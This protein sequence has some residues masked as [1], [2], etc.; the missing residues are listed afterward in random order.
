MSVP[1]FI[2]PKTK[3]EQ[4]FSDLDERPE[5]SLA[6]QIM[7]LKEEKDSHEG[8]VKEINKELD[9]WDDKETGEVHMGLHGK[10]AELLE[11]KGID[12]VRIKGLGSF[13][14]AS[15]N[16]P[17]VVDKEGL[18]HWLDENG[19]GAMAKRDVHWQTLKAF[20]T[21]WLKENKPLPPYINN[22]IQTKIRFRRTNSK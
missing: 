11:S 6:K 17:N 20:V 5:A 2:K 8:R 16:R 1:A 13:W 9:G 10:L 15:E 7:A 14:P 3:N 4:E 12:L 19:L 22:F 18:I 21:D